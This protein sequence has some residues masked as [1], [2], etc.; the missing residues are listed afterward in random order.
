MSA[1]T[2]GTGRLDDSP[3]VHRY[4]RWWLVSDA[5]A[6]PTDH[7]FASTLDTFARALL[8]AD[9]TIAH[10]PTPTTSRNPTASDTGGQQ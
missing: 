6:I 4:G 5:G 9:Q 2:S 8:D 10:L 1:L 3:A 7:V